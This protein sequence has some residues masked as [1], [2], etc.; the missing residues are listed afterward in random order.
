MRNDEGYLLQGDKQFKILGTQENIG[1][2]SDY[3]LTFIAS[4]FKEIKERVQNENN[5]YLNDYFRETFNVLEG[6]NVLK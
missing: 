5:E 2:C 3:E 1:S 4:Y 6:F